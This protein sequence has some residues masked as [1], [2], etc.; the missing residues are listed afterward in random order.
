[1][2]KTQPPSKTLGPRSKT[3]GCVAHGGLPDLACTP[4][5]AFTGASRAKIC[6]LGYSKSVR[7][8]SSSTKSRAYLEYGITS[9]T[10]GQYEVDHLVSLELGGANTISNL[11]PEAAEPIPGFHEKDLVEN[12][13]HRQVCNGELSLAAAQ[14]QEATNWLAIYRRMP[15]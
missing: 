3:S 7:Y 14:R 5:A 12:Y 10:R 2:R 1:V 8:V 11:W 15:H 4:G 9:H 13:L 6:K